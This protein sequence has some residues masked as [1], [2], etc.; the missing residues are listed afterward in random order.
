MT[1]RRPQ[2][3]AELIER[4]RAIDVRAPQSLHESLGALLGEHA[5]T[6]R[7]W[8]VLPRP[9]TSPVSRPRIAAAGALAAVALAFV[10]AFTLSGGGGSAPRLGPAGGVNPGPA[11]SAAPPVS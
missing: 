4:I 7:R 6:R 8:R 10:L 5:A 11:A 9:V 3:E 2:T 1:E